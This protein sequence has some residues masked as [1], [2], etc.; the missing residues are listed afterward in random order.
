MQHEGADHRIGF[1]VRTT[2]CD[3]CHSVL[4]AQWENSPL[5]LLRFI[6]QQASC[7]L[8]MLERYMIKPHEQLVLV[9]SMHCCT[10]TPSLSTLWS[11]RA[12]Q[13]SLGFAR[14]HLEVGFP[15]RCF[16]RL[17][18]PYI[19]TQRCHWRDNWNTRGMFNPVLSY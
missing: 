18:R 12:L 7:L 6:L 17:S 16:Q 19:A 9:S 15:L 13:E 5:I 8:R 1:E 4:T 10:S 2:A 14:S 3:Q 11:T